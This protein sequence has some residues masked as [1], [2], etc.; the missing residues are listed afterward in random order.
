[1]FGHVIWIQISFKALLKL[2]FSE[3]K[4]NWGVIFVND[5]NNHV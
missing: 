5:K 2:N 4:Y 3:I 1:M